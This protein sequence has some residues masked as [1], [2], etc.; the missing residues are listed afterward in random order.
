MVS[1]IL[2]PLGGLGGARGLSPPQI[3]LIDLDISPLWV[4]LNK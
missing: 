3:S 1:N 4:I 2:A